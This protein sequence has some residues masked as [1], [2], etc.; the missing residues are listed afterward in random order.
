MDALW[1]GESHNSSIFLV[2]PA[3]TAPFRQGLIGFPYHKYGKENQ[4]AS[5]DRGSF[6]LPFYTPVRLCYGHQSPAS[7]DFGLNDR[8]DQCITAD[9]EAF[10]TGEAVS[11]V[12]GYCCHALVRWYII[13]FGNEATGHRAIDQQEIDMIATKRVHR[14]GEEKTNIGL[15]YPS[16]VE[17][18][19]RT[20]YFNVSNKDNHER[21]FK[22]SKKDTEAA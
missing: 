10:S 7:L 22:V 5:R 1:I 13:I 19:S 3:R 12:S 21:I 2:I 6:L 15:H 9:R 16:P 11:H 20:L 4:P 18:S 8:A 14:E 17:S